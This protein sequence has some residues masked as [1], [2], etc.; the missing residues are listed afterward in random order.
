VRFRLFVKACLLPLALFGMFQSICSAQNALEPCRDRFADAYHARVAKTIDDAVI[1]PSSLRLTTLPSFQPESG[2][3][4]VD[5]EL[6]FVQFTS[7]FWADSYYR[8]AD[9][10]YRMDFARPKIATMVR[11]A[12]LSSMLA[13]R[14]EQV[15]ARAIAKAKHADGR[16]L[17]GVTYAFSTPNGACAYAWS[18][19]PDTSNGW[20][21]EL[22]GRLE[23]HAG[24][25]TPD[26]LQRSEKAMVGL[27]Q[28]ME[29]D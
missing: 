8:A 24:F 26:D 22:M 16:G 11:H 23:K 2:L 9:G 25:S 12:P 3:R 20:L 15:Y 10:S 5:T 4:L 27:L 19:K 6:Y 7:F 28:A 17:D 21:V 18:P 14:V 13:R 1:Q 29:K